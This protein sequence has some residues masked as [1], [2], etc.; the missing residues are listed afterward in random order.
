M[1]QASSTIDRVEVERC[2]VGSMLFLTEA[3]EFSTGELTGGEFSC[4]Q[5]R[6]QFRAVCDML[7]AGLP[8][9]P[10]ILAEQLAKRGNLEAAGGAIAIAE[11]SGDVFHAE[12]CRLY[13]GQLQSV[14]QRNELRCRSD[15]LRQQSED[16]SFEPGKTSDTHLQ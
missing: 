2:V 9:D 1:I 15:R 6:T 7:A 5:L 4:L 8:F 12:H 14:H 10:V 11:T 16:P 3:A 13:V